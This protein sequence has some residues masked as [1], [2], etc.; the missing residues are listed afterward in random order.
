VQISLD[1]LSGSDLPIPTWSYSTFPR[2]E[3]TLR[4]HQGTRFSIVAGARALQKQSF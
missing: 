2:V 4:E 1:D 3:F